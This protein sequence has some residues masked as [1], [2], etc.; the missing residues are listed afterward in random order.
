MLI[1][2][3]LLVHFSAVEAFITS[4]AIL[5]PLPLILR[6]KM[7][8]I[9]GDC[10]ACVTKVAIL[11]LWYQTSK[12]CKFV[13]HV[14]LSVLLC[15]GN[16]Y[17]VLQYDHTHLISFHRVLK[18][19]DVNLPFHHFRCWNRAENIRLIAYSFSPWWLGE[20][21][22][23]ALTF[24]S[25]NSSRKDCIHKH[26]VFDT[27]FASKVWMYRLDALQECQ[28]IQARTIFLKPS[29]KSIKTEAL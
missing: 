23:I 8:K 16:K 15:T 6:G 27:Q 13:W 28:I 7:S 19:G 25:R 21:L 1:F 20:L 22:K 2:H 24:G 29:R 5:H 26:M 17:L 12:V 14:Y 10:L 3:V 11:N 9:S 4:S 18:R